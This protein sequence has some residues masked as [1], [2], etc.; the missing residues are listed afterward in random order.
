MVARLQLLL[1]M[2]IIVLQIRVAFVKNFRFDTLR[3]IMQDSH[4][5][6]RDTIILCNGFIWKS[7][8]IKYHQMLS[9]VVFTGQNRVSTS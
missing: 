5:T 6:Y 1:L 3:N 8:V 9:K 7:A 2:Y 4:K